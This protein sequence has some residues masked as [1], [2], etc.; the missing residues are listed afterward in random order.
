MLEQPDESLAAWGAAL[1]RTKSSRRKLMWL[2]AACAVCCAALLATAALPPR[3]LLAWNASASMP[4]GLYRIIP[5]ASLDVG[6][7]VIA[8]LP[9]NVRRLAAQRHYLPLGVPL[10]KDVAASAGQR[11]CADGG[12]VS[13]DGRNVVLRRRADRRHR[14]LPWWFGCRVLQEGSVFLLGRA[15]DSFDGRYFGPTSAS[16]V[17]GRAE[18]LWLR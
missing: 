14:A 8:R 3:P 12:T 11:V 6:D 16:D 13:I 18:P 10:V 17:V 1:R 15:A 2:A 7:L 4:P 9:P 5:G